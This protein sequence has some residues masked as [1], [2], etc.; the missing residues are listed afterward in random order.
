ML[1]D[2]QAPNE[3]P[4]HVPDQLTDSVQPGHHRRPRD[5]V[6]RGDPGNGAQLAAHLVHQALGK[7]GGDPG[8]K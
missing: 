8:A 7:P 2:A 3:H 4:V 6:R 1:V 5:P